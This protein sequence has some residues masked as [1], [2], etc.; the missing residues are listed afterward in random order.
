MTV[1]EDGRDLRQKVAQACRIIAHRDLAAGVLGHVSA[2]VSETEIVVRC[3]GP[4][5]RGLAATVAG[6]VWRMTLDG[7]SVDLPAGY[8]PPK[9]LAL[10]TEVFR[11][12]P[13]VGA[14]V[15]AHPRSAL[16]CGLAGLEPRP[17]FGAYDIP[18]TRLAAKGI[19]VYPRG[20]LVARRELAREMV[21]AMDGADVC[22]LRGHGV[23]V[24]GDDVEAAIVRCVAL[25]TVLEVTV[26]LAQLGAAPEGVSDG[27]LADL[28]D[29]GPS[30]NER[31]SWRA[32]LAEL[33][34]A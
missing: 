18:A 33:P 2:R 29:L 19:P 25:N 24:V 1:L 26:E 9:E 22:L 34:D 8:A 12:R 4:K 3:R 11:L 14:V 16:L 23:T 17:V 30:F 28:P 7:E 10:H 27:D 6:D 5:E 15:H 32:L 21:A 13:E 20:V 31:Q